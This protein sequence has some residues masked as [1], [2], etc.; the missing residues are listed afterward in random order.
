MDDASTKIS[1]QV[2]SQDVVARL[3]LFGKDAENGIVGVQD[4][5]Y[6]LQGLQKAFQHI[7]G[8]YEPAVMD[9]SFNL[10][11]ALS[12]G[13]LITEISQ[14]WWCAPVI[15][16]STWFSKAFCEKLGEQAG[17]K[18]AELFHF[19]KKEEFAENMK[20]IPF[21]LYRMIVIAKHLNGIG[22]NIINEAQIIPLANGN[23]EL[24]NE[25]DEKLEITTEEMDLFKACD[26]KIF[27]IL[28]TP[29][30][31]NLQLEYSYI[32]SNNTKKSVD[33]TS[34]DRE[35]F[36][37]PE[38][39]EEDEP[40]VVL[41]ELLDGHYYELEGKINRV[42]EKTC[43]LG[44]FYK[45]HTITS[46]P[47]DKQLATYKNSFLSKK[48]NQVLARVR[49]SGIIERKD[50]SSGFM[51]NRPIMNFDKLELLDDEHEEDELF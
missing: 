7:A 48:S 26:S 24:H 49:I 38:D 22:A 18:V 19:N 35:Y 30:R 50:F 41:S 5:I 27:S 40:V 4:S 28:V 11:V 1:M 46:I 2:V 39:V 8:H 6:A 47:V 43:S 45:G 16:G 25:L 33:I 34:E 31:P 12:R 23:W 21:L 36:Y 44:F 29:L 9:E 15:A 32:A 37:F 10:P 20:R 13:S 51:R 14:N 3:R 17:I 42:T